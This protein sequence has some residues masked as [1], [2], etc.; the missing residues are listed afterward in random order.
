M[1][2]VLVGVKVEKKVEYGEFGAIMNVSLINDV[3]VSIVIDT[4]NR[5]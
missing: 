1:G 3:P 5:E 2:K 4:K